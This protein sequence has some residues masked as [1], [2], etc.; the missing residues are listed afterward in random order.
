VGLALGVLVLLAGCFGFLGSST[1]GSLTEDW[2]SDT[3]RDIQGN[4]HAVAAARIDGKPMVFAP[5]SGHAHSDQTAADGHQHSHANGCALVGLNGTTGAQQW[6]NPT[7]EQACTIHAVADPAVADVDGDGDVEVVA[8]TTEERVTVS[9]PTTGFLQS[10][11]ELS[12]YGFTKPLVA[13]FLANEQSGSNAS[14]IAVVDVRG[15]VVVLRGTNVLWRQDLSGDVQAQPRAVDLDDDPQ[16]E[17]VVGTMRGAVVALDPGNGVRWNQTLDGASVTWLTAG[18][19]DDDPESEVAAATY[20]GDVVLLDDDGS[21]LWR[22]NLGR[23]A[24]VDAFTD[25]DGDGEAELY[26]SNKT[27]TVTAFSANGS[28]EWER[29]VADE[30]TQM[31][32]PPVVGDVSGDGAPE[33]VVADNAGGVTVLDPKSG[34]VLARYSRDVPIWTHPTLVDLDGDG[35]DEI[36]VM[37][38]DGRVARLSY[39]PPN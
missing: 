1:P 24:A 33:V 7:T 31:T 13:D 23:L 21:V 38:G 34:E 9:D 25:G 19:A 28:V 17:L 4:H 29:D 11:A 22:K 36:L 6:T 8:A 37:Y 16:R 39:D 32:P 14:E 10:T 3:E 26:A 5:L 15:Q 30:A 2:L 35:A 27:G 12:A 18:Q 20:Q